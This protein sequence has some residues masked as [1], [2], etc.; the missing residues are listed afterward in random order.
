MTEWPRTLR[1][2]QTRVTATSDKNAIFAAA[3]TAAA[4]G[5]PQFVALV[6]AI[7][8]A[9]RTGSEPKEVVA[10]FDALAASIAKAESGE[11]ASIVLAHAC[12]EALQRNPSVKT[13]SYLWSLAW[14]DLPEAVTA[15]AK[16]D[17]AFK[18]SFLEVASAKRRKR[19]RRCR[20]G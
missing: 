19:S 6:D 11:I 7:A 10:K 18:S 3:R 4:R 14:H 8:K 13:W 5:R 9:C 16:E 12:V 1:L 2:R 20:H 15:A 17:V